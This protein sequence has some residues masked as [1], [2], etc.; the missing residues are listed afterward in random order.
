MEE[1]KESILTKLL[2]KEL[3]WLTVD[4]FF[5]EDK[6]GFKET[7]RYSQVQHTCLV[8]CQK[9]TTLNNQHE[10]QGDTSCNPIAAPVT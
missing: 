6:K 10:T 8:K 9:Q 2:N 5:C 3:C 4:F 1:S 7:L